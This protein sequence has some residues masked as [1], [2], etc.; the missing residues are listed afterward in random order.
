MKKTLAITAAA[1]QAT[2]LLAGCKGRTTETTES[3]G[4]AP[5]EVV[6]PETESAE[7]ARDSLQQKVQH[8]APAQPTQESNPVNDEAK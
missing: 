8:S 4:S 7:E 1:I 6:I 5:V 3:D 2:A